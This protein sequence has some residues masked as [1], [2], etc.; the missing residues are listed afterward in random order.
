MKN[1]IVP[2]CEVYEVMVRCGSDV[3]SSKRQVITLRYVTF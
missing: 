1:Y 3:L 2:D